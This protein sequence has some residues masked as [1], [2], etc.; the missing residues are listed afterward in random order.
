MSREVVLDIVQERLGFP[1]LPLLFMKDDLVGQGR[2]LE[3]SKIYNLLPPSCTNSNIRAIRRGERD[4]YVRERSDSR[5]SDR[6]KRDWSRYG[7]HT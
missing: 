6:R 4:S 5:D 2:K 7:Q 3:S 1:H